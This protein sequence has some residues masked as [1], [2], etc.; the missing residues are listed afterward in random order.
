MENKV[1]HI[2][3][4][5]LSKHITEIFYNKLNHIRI[6]ICYESKKKLKNLKLWMS[7]KDINDLIKGMIKDKNLKKFQV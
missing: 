4:I 6:I 5:K 3:K 1:Y 7:I 2:N